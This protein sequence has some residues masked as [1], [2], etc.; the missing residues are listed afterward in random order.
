M[1]VRVVFGMPDTEYFAVPALSQSLAKQ[2]LVSPLDG[3]WASWMN[4][5]CPTESETESAARRYGK[6]LHK[7]LLE[8]ADAF[9]ACYCAKPNPD[10]Y[11]HALRTVED[12]REVCRARGLKVSG[13]RDDL[14]ARI[15]DDNFGA[16]FW[17]DLYTDLVNG[18]ETLSTDMLANIEARARIIAAMPDVK[19]AIQGGEPEVSVFWEE[20]TQFGPVPCKARFDY[21]RADAFILDVK[22]F[23]NPQ[24]KPIEAAIGA[25]M[26]NNRYHLQAA[27]YLRACAVL[28]QAARNGS[29]KIEGGHLAAAIPKAKRARFGFLFVQSDG[30]PN[31]L[32]R[33]VAE[34]NSHGGLG[35]TQNGYFA[36]AQ[37]AM[38]EALR[39]FAYFTDACGDSPWLMPDKP[40]AFTD[41]DLPIW[42]QD[43]LVA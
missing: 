39:R 43:S 2:L 41:D 38:A 7:R 13:N 28:I 3:W 17:D 27:W 20:A 22:S 18:R 26:A 9:A 23:S 25:A 5:A 31:V 11:P 24:S 36:R 42:I 12:M 30:A 32:F 4:P 1:T 10:D 34:F 21:L 6:A 8:G 29:V 14:I 35:M 16:I 15:R 40:R 19:N 37:E 33:E